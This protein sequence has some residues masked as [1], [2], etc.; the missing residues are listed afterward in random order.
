MKKKKNG[1]RDSKFGWV[2]SYLIQLTL[3]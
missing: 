1:D 3:W 2:P